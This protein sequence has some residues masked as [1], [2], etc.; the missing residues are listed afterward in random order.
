[1]NQ[2]QKTPAEREAIKAAKKAFKTNNG[3]PLEP[4]V[5]SSTPTT[6]KLPPILNGPI[7]E[8]ENILDI[9]YP[10]YWGYYYLAVFHDYSTQVIRSDIKGDLRDLIMDLEKRGYKNI[11][12]IRNCKLFQRNLL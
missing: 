6:R 10:V 9:H 8:G 4:F 7:S 2:F 11:N 1:M 3:T 5:G 12:H